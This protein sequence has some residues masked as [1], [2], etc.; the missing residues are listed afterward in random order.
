MNTQKL[1]L[2]V[3]TAALAL[4][5][6]L[7][8]VSA[9]VLFQEDWENTTITATGGAIVTKTEGAGTWTSAFFNGA[10]NSGNNNLSIRNDVPPTV[11]GSHSVRY[12]DASGAGN[13]P[14]LAATFSSSTTSALSVAFDYKVMAGGDGVPALALRSSNNTVG[15]ALNLYNN[16]KLTLGG[17]ETISITTNAW[18]HVEITTSIAGTAGELTVSVRKHGEQNVE[19][20]TGSFTTNLDDYNSLRFNSASGSTTDYY[21]D[22]ITV[23]AIP[24][25][26]TKAYVSIIGLV[27]LLLWFRRCRCAKA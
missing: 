12:Y 3:S 18:Y 21:L 11:G 14:V 10:T 22:N 1:P 6:L 15:F 23:T 17:T 26:A 13:I 24:E 4:G 7:S 5:C 8:N 16:G 25:P 20:I 19:T 27:G 2:L 9:Q